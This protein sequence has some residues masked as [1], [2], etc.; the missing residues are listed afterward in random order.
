MIPKVYG[1][2]QKQHT[3]ALNNIA[4]LVWQRMKLKLVDMQQPLHLFLDSDGTHCV[5]LLAKVHKGHMKPC[6]MVSC[7]LE[8][9]KVTAAPL[10]Q[11]LVAV[12][13]VS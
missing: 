7:L 1:Q 9:T 8:A 10:E 12:L 6:A 3:S 2:W 13:W 5:V 4:K 11:L